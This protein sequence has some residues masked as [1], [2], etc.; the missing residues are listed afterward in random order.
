MLSFATEITEN[1]NFNFVHLIPPTPVKD[2]EVK[3]K[4]R[5]KSWVMCNR[6]FPLN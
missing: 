3:C 5:G 6:A 1:E 2:K 4:L